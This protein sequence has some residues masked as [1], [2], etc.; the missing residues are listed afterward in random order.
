[1][2]RTGTVHVYRDRKREWRWRAVSANG[3][4]IANG[5]E[6]YRNKKACWMVAFKVS[7]ALKYEIKTHA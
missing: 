6:S 4:K 1:M 5:G 3:R 7:L 2:R